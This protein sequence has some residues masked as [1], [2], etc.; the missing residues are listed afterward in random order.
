M[1]AC[2][3]LVA[4]DSPSTLAAA[5]YAVDLA[6]RLGA[7]ITAV[8][9]IADGILT[10]TVTRV[11]GQ[12]DVGARRDLA[13]RSVLAHVEQLARLAEVEMETVRLFGDIAER[14][15]DEARRIRP[16]L[17]VLGRDD[18]PR[19]GGRALAPWADR[20]L[21]FAERPVLVVPGSRNPRRPATP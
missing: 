19:P 7:R 8:N 13:G 10:D 21:E 5:R 11:S 20:I 16:D 9:V 18:A 4:E 12:P 14:V 15:L 17:I 6:H 1:T 3:L 2:L